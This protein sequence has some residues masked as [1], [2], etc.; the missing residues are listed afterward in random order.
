[1]EGLFKNVHI[2]PLVIIDKKGKKGPTFIDK[3]YQCLL[4]NSAKIL[5]EF[6]VHLLF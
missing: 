1:M 2:F 4:V 5:E 3:K 6:G